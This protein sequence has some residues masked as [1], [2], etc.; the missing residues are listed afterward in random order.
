MITVQEMIDALSKYPPDANCYAYEGEITGV[1][2]VAP[3]RDRKELGYIYA[4]ETRTS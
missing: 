1:V 3:T 4:H 2:I